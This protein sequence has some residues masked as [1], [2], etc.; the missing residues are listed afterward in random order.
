MPFLLTMTKDGLFQKY[1]N[2]FPPLLRDRLCSVQN[3]KAI[4]SFLLFRERH[5]TKLNADPA[6]QILPLQG[7]VRKARWVCP[8]QKKSSVG[9]WTFIPPHQ[10]AW[11]PPLICPLQPDLYHL[12]IR[13]SSLPSWYMTLCIPW[14]LS[15]FALERSFPQNIPSYSGYHQTIISVR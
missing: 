8:A 15:A 13:R 9:L 1:K 2:V 4:T 12:A 5:K 6:S 7:T 3:V 14:M 11:I 10:A